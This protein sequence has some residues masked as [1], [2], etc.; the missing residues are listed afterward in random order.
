MPDAVVKA[1]RLFTP[2]ALR[3]GD[4]ATVDLL[5]PSVERSIKGRSHHGRLLICPSPLVTHGEGSIYHVEALEGIGAPLNRG[6]G[7]QE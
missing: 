2:R 4:L 7:R 5:I 3:G 1:I 6:H